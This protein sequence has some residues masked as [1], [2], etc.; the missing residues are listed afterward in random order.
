MKKNEG[1]G[2]EA[3]KYD[4]GE[5]RWAEEEGRRRRAGGKPNDGEKKPAARRRAGRSSPEFYWKTWKDFGELRRPWKPM[6]TLGNPWK[7][8][9]AGG[10]EG[11]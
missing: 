3:K 8:G 9:E 5:D 2:A 11:K 4:G 7:R 1:P 10:G 6:K